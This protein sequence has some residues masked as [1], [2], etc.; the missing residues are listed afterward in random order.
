MKKLYI[1]LFTAFFI[2]AL[3]ACGSNK[4]V[5]EPKT[6]ILK[7]EDVVSMQVVGGLHGTK[8]SPLYK[9]SDATGK[10][11]ITK[12]VGWINSSVPLGTQPEYGRHGYPMILKIQMNVGKPI[13]VEPG[14]KCVTL[15][16]PPT[17]IHISEQTQIGTMKS[18][19]AVKDEIVL[20][21]TSIN[22]RAKSPELYEWLNR[23]WKTE[24]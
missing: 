23:R 15:K 22:L 20:S 5:F 6:P 18:C 16:S 13:Y 2:F 21:N 12:I 3:S 8:P 14:Y 10:A 9:I 1:G 17:D 24:Q 19:G 4:E 7:V 11:L